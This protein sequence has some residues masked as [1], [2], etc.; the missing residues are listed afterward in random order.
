M[1]ISFIPIQIRNDIKAF[2]TGHVIKLVIEEFNKTNERVTLNL[3][4]SERIHDN[5]DSI[6][7]VVIKESKID[8]KQKL[9]SENKHLIK[10]GFKCK[11]KVVHKAEYGYIIELENGL[12]GLL[13]IT[14]IPKHI[15]LKLFETIDVTI[16]K[17]NLEKKQISFKL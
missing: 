1:P 12:D 6:K 11:G 10:I 7:K 3:I 5:K 8:K 17:I 4:V 13:H 16:M 9:W 15:E 14:K 2:E